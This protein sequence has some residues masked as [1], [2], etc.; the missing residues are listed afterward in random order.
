M[1]KKE[2]RRIAEED[3][4]LT[5]LLELRENS[6]QPPEHLFRVEAIWHACMPRMYI[7]SCQA[8]LNRLYR[9]GYVC[10]N[11]E[12]ARRRPATIDWAR[13]TDPD[14]TRERLEHVRVPQSERLRNSLLAS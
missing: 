10:N 2:Q 11:V 7:A 1:E 13:L 4:V 12:D 5:A 9:A 6:S 14:A 8:A 3:L